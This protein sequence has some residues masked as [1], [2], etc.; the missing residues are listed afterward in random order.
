M[1]LK[2]ILA[3]SGQPGLYQFIARSSNGVIVESLTDKKRM[4]ASG[5]SKISSL[6]EISVYTESEDRPLWQILESMYA[7]TEGKPTVSHKSEAGEIKK[8]FADVIPDYD[9]ERVH[10]S[11]M[12]KIVAWFNIL[13]EAGMT[14]FKIE[15]EE[16]ESEQADSAPQDDKPEEE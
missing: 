16:A 5:T 2:D 13:V 1:E 9:R 14:E 8:L 3:I 12:K 11:D 7:F 4:N 15:E 6:A 10:F